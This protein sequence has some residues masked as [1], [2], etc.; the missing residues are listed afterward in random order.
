MPALDQIPHFHQALAATPNMIY[1][2]RYAPSDLARIYGDAHF[3]WAMDFYEA[4][5]NSDWLLPNR[6]YESLAYG[7]VPIAVSCVETARWLE[8]HNVGA[9]LDEPLPEQLA[10][11]FASL[12]AEKMEALIKAAEQRDPSLVSVDLRACRDFAAKVIGAAA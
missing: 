3:A 6:L 2:G 5:G 9:V 8:A 11:F 7:S 4:G 1:H 12:T 10:K